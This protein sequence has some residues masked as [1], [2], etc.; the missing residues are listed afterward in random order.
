MGVG[1]A[2]YLGELSSALTA[3]GAASPVGIHL[4]AFIAG[5]AARG[6]GRLPLCSA[7]AGS[8][9]RVPA[10]RLSPA[11]KR[12]GFPWARQTERGNGEKPWVAE[13]WG[14]RKC[15][16]EKT[17]RVCGRGDVLAGRRKNVCVCMRRWR[18][19]AS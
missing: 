2:P 17:A 1:A 12:E 19:A 13:S 7:P 15:V 14:K 4:A 5:V 3:R 16:G 11:G 6:G 18:A 10:E 8:V 9:K